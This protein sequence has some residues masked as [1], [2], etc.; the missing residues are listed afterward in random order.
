MTETRKDTICKEL[1]AADSSQHIHV[2]TWINS[3]CLVIGV[4][5]LILIV[6]QKKII[7][8]TDV[9]NV[10]YRQK[11]D[12]TLHSTENTDCEAIINK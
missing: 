6:T 8:K 11:E 4:I 10:F 7:R 3:V 5:V 12:E 2:T 1:H 9:A